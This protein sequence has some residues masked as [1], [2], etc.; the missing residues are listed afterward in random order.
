MEA[1]PQNLQNVL[2]LLPRLPD[3]LLIPIYTKYLRKYRIDKDG[4]FIK[5]IDFEK[6]K[7]L[8]RVISRKIVSVSKVRMYEEYTG[9]ELQTNII[10]IKY[11][12]SNWCHL[13]DRE[14]QLIEDDMMY[15]YLNTDTGSYTIEKHRLIKIK[16]FFTKN[17]PVSMYSRRN[18][19]I[20]NYLD[21]DWEV[22]TLNLEVPL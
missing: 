9:R 17:K 15:V 3:D 22:F 13:P 5:L 8:E 12:L 21:Y 11:K 20:G 19:P 10:E 14:E 2:H 7:F 4:N 18:F 1:F 6:Y 16:E